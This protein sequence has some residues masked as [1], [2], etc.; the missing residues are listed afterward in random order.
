MSK[1][2]WTA[3]ITFFVILLI[4]F[5]LLAR[6]ARNPYGLE[7][8]RLG[9]AR[10]KLAQA[11]TIEPN[12]KN[13]LLHKYLDDPGYVI[14]IAL[15]NHYIH[16]SNTTQKI[17]NTDGLFAIMYYPG[18]NGKFHSENKSLPECNG[19]CNGNVSASLEIDRRSAKTITLEKLERLSRDRSNKDRLL[20]FEDLEPIFDFDQRFQ[21]RYPEA[22]KRSNGNKSSTDDYFIKKD[23]NGI[24]EYLLACHPYVPSPSCSVIFNSS[25]RPELLVELTFSMDLLGEWKKVINAADKQISSWP[26]KKIETIKQ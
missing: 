23:A 2:F 21:V 17:L 19:W 25:S 3:I 12:A 1:K 15:P 26:T 14:H 6:W 22:E 18:M 7:P 10:K 5:F 4:L 16:P 13:Y 8:E 11:V 9:P 24:P 20:S